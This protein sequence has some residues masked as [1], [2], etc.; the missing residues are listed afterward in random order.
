[1]T[2]S[3]RSRQ[4]ITAARRRWAPLK[5]SLPKAG[6]AA[7]DRLFDG[8]TRHVQAGVWMS[9]PSASETLV[10]AMLLEQRQVLE[11]ILVQ[12]ETL[13]A[14]PTQSCGC[15]SRSHWTTSPRPRRS[16]VHEPREELARGEVR[17]LEEVRREFGR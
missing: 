7:F 1:M 8:A 6:Q 15:C 4:L 16:A 2:L 10:M 13:S 11:R 17:T 3:R 12:V 5:R 14:P 9:R